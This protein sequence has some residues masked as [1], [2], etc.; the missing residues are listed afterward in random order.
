VTRIYLDYNASAPLRPEARAA[1]TAAWDVVGNASSVHWHGRR[2]HALIEQAR[3][4]VAAA[5]GAAPAGV[6]FTAGGTE[7]NNLALAFGAERPLLVSAIEHDSVLRTAFARGGAVVPATAAGTVDLD[8]LDR[9]LAAAGP[10]ALVALMAVNNETGVIQP[11]AEAVAM[12]RRHGALV[13]CDAVQALG[14]VPLDM[15]ALGV[16]MLALSAHKIGGPQGV[17]ALV[18]REGVAP[19]PLLHGGGQERGRRPGTQNVAGIAGFAAAVAVTAAGEGADLAGWRDAMEARIVAGCPTA[20][21][22]GANAPRVGGVSCI[23]LPGLRAETQL[24]MLDLEGFSVS[25]G[26]ACS[27]GKVSQSH[28]LGAMGLDEA[29]AGCAIRVSAGW[30]SRR[31]ELEAFADAWLAMAAKHGR[32]A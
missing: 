2:A 6:V 25:A 3:E 7:A 21:V 27:S 14:R 24:M 8:S 23:A 9:Q 19:P 13:H 20:V 32:A 10:G 17:G 29:V 5:V 16:D 28:V 22:A 4:T 26:S 30:A 31:E 11:V 15:A 1:M 12:A 18:L